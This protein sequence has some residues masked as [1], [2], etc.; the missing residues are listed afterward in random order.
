MKPPLI[1][2]DLWA[3]IA[4]FLDAGKTG[5]IV[6]AVKRGHVT[7]GQVVSSWQNPEPAPTRVVRCGE[8]GARR[9]PSEQ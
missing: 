9:V 5:Q 8:P 7:G 3:Q 1:P 4:E 6:I 2:D